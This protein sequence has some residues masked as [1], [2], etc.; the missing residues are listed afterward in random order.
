MT[1]HEIN[2]LIEHIVYNRTVFGPQPSH[3][4]DYASHPTRC[5]HCG[6]EMWSAAS[7]LGYPCNPQP[8]DF[9]GNDKLA[10]QLVAELILR[11]WYVLVRHDPL[12]PN[13]CYTAML[14]PPG[15]NEGT[16]IDAETRAGAITGSFAL[17]V[18]EPQA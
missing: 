1:S 4:W 12:R 18:K 5:K 3:K 15:N 13:R 10:V 17:A 7:L 8:R 16:R 2:L 14:N 6:V 11:D 9:A